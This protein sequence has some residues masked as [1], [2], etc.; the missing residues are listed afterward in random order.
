MNVV[1]DISI[2][3]FHQFKK[4]IRGSR[5][6]LIVGIDVVKKKHHALFTTV[7]G[8]TLVRRLVFDNSLEGFRNH[9]VARYFPEMD[10]MGGHSE[11]ESLAIVR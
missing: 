5:K 11:P 9:L 7:I 4:E 2:D 1:D 8:N 6:N 10:R 3:A